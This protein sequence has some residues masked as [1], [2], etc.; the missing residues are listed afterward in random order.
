M[1]IYQMVW[2][3]GIF[4]GKENMFLKILWKGWES[5][6][7]ILKLIKY[8]SKNSKLFWVDDTIHYK[9]THTIHNLHNLSFF[10]N[11]LDLNKQNNN[12]L[13]ES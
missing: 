9:N 2:N 11:V 5:N 1:F 12:K 8:P 13:D 3:E 6:L 7:H 10:D 4:F